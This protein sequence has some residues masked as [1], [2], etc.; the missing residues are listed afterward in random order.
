MSSICSMSIGRSCFS[1][2]CSCLEGQHDLFL[3]FA[4]LRVEPPSHHWVRPHAP[5]SQTSVSSQCVCQCELCPKLK[6][7]PSAF[8][9]QS[10][11]KS[12]FF[13]ALGEV[14][15]AKLWTVTRLPL[16]VFFWPLP[17]TSLQSNDL[18]CCGTM[19]HPTSASQ[20]FLWKGHGF[21]SVL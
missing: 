7:S 10:G 15:H 13:A 19:W 6:A 8:G 9:S 2:F 17:E 1:D 20:F 5:W 14:E 21:T 16:F 4:C 12:G 11:W 3:G 18:A